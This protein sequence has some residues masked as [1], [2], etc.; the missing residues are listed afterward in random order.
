MPLETGA[1]LPPSYFIEEA[2]FTWWITSAPPYYC[3]NPTPGGSD[4]SGDE[5][6]CGVSVW[7]ES[8]TPIEVYSTGLKYAY[9]FNGAGE[10]PSPSPRY[11]AS[12]AGGTP[13]W[14]PRW[15]PL[16]TP[17]GPY[18]PEWDRPQSGEYSLGPGR[19]PLFFGPYDLNK[20]TNNL[21]YPV[22]QGDVI[23]IATGSDVLG[24]TNEG[25]PYSVT[26]GRVFNLLFYS[27]GSNYAWE[28]GKSLGG[29]N[30]YFPDYSITSRYIFVRETSI[31]GFVALP[32]FENPSQVM[33]W[34]IMWNETTN[35][36]VNSINAS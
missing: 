20:T 7:P 8:S 10:T 6:W 19:L 36:Y 3:K 18:S 26:D 23:F 21:S 17:A 1:S 28:L 31:Y 24:G 22:S 27:T 4:F 5:T 12:V 29:N 34:P 9:T 33:W 11:L 32:N 30:A 15:E 2:N 16:N 25:P 14:A 35:H 13:T